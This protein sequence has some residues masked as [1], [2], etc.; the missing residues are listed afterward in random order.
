[1][2]RSLAAALALAPALGA[3]SSVATPRAIATISRRSFGSPKL[4]DAP[5]YRVALFAHA[6]LGSSGAQ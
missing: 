5:R 4:M 6:E 1:M 2:N 3:Q